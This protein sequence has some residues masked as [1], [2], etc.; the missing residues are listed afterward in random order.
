MKYLLFL[1]FLLSIIHTELIKPNNL[2]TLSKTHVLF[3]WKQEPYAIGYN[4]Q[5][6]NSNLF[7]EVFVDT[8]I[9]NLIHIDQHNLDWDNTYFWRIKPIFEDSFG[10]WI[11]VSSFSISNSIFN[12]IT[13]EIEIHDEEIIQ[14][15]LTIFG[16]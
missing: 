16:D 1:A 12:T 2:D 7:D 9:Y 15:D 13:D 11:D 6:G 8:N 5:I 10:D 14:E 4:F 3:E